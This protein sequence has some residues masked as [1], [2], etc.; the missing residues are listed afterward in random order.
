MLRWVSEKLTAGR[1]GILRVFRRATTD[2]PRVSS[3]PLNPKVL[4]G[5]TAALLS[6]SAG[7][8]NPFH[9]SSLL[10]G[11]RSLAVTS[12]P[13]SPKIVTYT[14]TLVEQQIKRKVYPYSLVPGGALDVTQAKHLMSDP[15][16][17]VSTRT[18]IWRS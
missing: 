1:G 6:A 9:F 15:A 7:L 13:A 12:R 4:I 2:K 10:P 5:V 18:L 14:T 8:L 11:Q 16:I 3:L 17:K